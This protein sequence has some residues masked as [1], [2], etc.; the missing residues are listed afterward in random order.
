MAGDEITR[1]IQIVP[2]RES[3][4]L[5]GYRMNIEIGQV[6]LDSSLLNARLR[7]DL[8]DDWFPDPLGYEDMFSE[9]LIAEIL[10]TNYEQ[11][12][13]TYVAS[14][15]TLY[16]IPKTGFTLR[17]ALETSLSDRALYHGLVS[18]LMPFYDAHIPWN[19]FS[20]RYDYE[21]ER[22]RNKYL[23]KPSIESWKNFVGAATSAVSSDNWLLSTDLSNY[24]E[25][26]ELSILKQSLLQLVPKLDV[27]VRG[28]SDVRAHI[29]FLFSS[30][31][32]W[33][34]SADR[35]L[36]QNRDASS[37]LANVY[38]RQVD[39]AMIELG[40]GERYFRYMDD[41]KIICSDEFQ[42]RLALK[43]L[44][45]ALRPLG[46]TINA[47]KTAIVPGTDAEQIAKCLDQQKSAVEQMDSMWRQK[48]RSSL[49]ALIPQLRTRILQLV[50]A[51]EVDS[52]EFRYCIKRLELL[53]R[54]KD[55]Y[56]PKQFYAGITYAISTA[57]VKYPASTDQY[58]RYLSA[59]ET[60]ETELSPIVDY[61][62]SESQSIYSWQNYRLWLLLVEKKLSTPA[63]LERARKL[64][65]TADSPN[66]AAAS[67]FLGCCGT[68]DD[69][70]LV[71]ENF[72]TLDSFLGQRA[73]LLAIHELPFKPHVTT[74]VR[75]HIR[76]DLFGVY[77][78]LK[79]SKRRGA[80]IQPKED[81]HFDSGDR[82]EVA[83]E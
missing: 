41:I 12:H 45:I 83:Y 37:F 48:T 15:R 26:I 2:I 81:L 57:V 27:D 66:R 62:L 58:V 42:A 73:A 9:G 52:R 59:A 14:N 82:D 40:Y 19:V 51:G 60:T 70:I 80:Y 13:G 33:T 79:K 22:S 65:R 76:P 32:K 44:S 71:A 72:R 39:L 46:L 21:K 16:N 34:F 68:E 7:V 5:V 35:G 25:N 74:S 3:E 49:F 67:V 69:R 47:K 8:R 30:L 31:A 38:M 56:V 54:Y 78:A 24:F 4:S 6:S 36:P 23:F 10:N 55:L 53:I 43:Q 77:R 64:V 50:G 11:N 1:S 75:P 20:H 63:L 28:K 29:D 17:Y 18:F 61:L